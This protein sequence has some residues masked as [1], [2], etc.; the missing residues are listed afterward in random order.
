MFL[1]WAR[2]VDPLVEC[3]LIMHQALGSLP[4]TKQKQTNK[5]MPGGAQL[6]SGSRRI[7]SSRSPLAT[8]EFKARSYFKK[9]ST[10][11]GEP[12]LANGL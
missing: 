5:S 7:R 4:S 9:A 8:R 2:G 3:L 11:M 10:L 1:Y 6:H 12:P